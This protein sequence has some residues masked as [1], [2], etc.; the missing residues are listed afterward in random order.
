MLSMKLRHKYMGR[1]NYL[2][3]KFGWHTKA[4]YILIRLKREVKK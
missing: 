2:G 3:S 1:L 4:Y